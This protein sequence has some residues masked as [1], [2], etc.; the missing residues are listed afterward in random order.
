MWHDFGL[1]KLDQPKGAHTRR[2]E[3]VRKGEP[4]TAAQYR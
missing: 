1:T 3:D 2:Y 4:A